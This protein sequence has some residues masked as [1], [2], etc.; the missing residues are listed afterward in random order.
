MQL[1]RKYAYGAK[2]CFCRIEGGGGG[3]GQGRDMNI[4]SGVTHFYGFATH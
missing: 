4:R 2:G 1:S 3:R